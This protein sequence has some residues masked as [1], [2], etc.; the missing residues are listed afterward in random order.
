MVR[1]VRGHDQSG[2][3]RERE[4]YIYIER[5]RAVGEVV[6][7]KVFTVKQISEGDGAAAAADTESGVQR[8]LRQLH[9]VLLLAFPLCSHELQES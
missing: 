3:E 9:P 1:G 5:E 6:N 7:D 2:Q 4:I 8:V